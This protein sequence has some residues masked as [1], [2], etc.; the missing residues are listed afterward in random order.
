MRDRRAL[1]TH[2]LHREGVTNM[3]RT[4]KSIFGGLVGLVASAGAAAAGPV[5]FFTLETET[6]YRF[7]GAF[8]DP[9]EEMPGVF[10]PFVTGSDAGVTF[11][12]TPGQAQRFGIPRP[13]IQASLSAQLPGGSA[14]GGGSSRPDVS[15]SGDSDTFFGAQSGALRFDLDPSL[16]ELDRLTGKTVDSWGFDLDGPFAISGRLDAFAG[17]EVSAGVGYEFGVFFDLVAADGSLLRS[18]EASDSLGGR[19]DEQFG[20]QI[21]QDNEAIA[22]GPVTLLVRSEIALFGIED[23][24]LSEPRLEGDADFQLSYELTFVALEDPDGRIPAPGAA[25][26]LAGGL[27]VARRRRG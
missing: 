18:F 16:G 22:A 13:R 20:F 15:S 27:L 12:G 6:D 9:S 17:G 2:A 3:G 23:A 14:S 19:I 1:F 4:R 21:D 10:D 7:S 26:L 24:D 8:A 25:A 5:G 11:A